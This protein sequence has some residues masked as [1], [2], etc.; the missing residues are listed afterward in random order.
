M[1]KIIIIQG[2]VIEKSWFEW[3]LK[4]HSVGCM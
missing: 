4:E 3:E 1:I 2:I